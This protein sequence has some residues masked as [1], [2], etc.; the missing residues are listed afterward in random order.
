MAHALGFDGTEE[1][2]RTFG[3][4]TPLLDPDEIVFFAVGTDNLTSYER[5]QR[6]ARGLRAI[7]APAVAADPEA[8]AAEA[9][10]MLGTTDRILVHLDVDTIDYMDLPL[11]ENA[12]RNEGLAFDTTMRALATL[13]ATPKLAALTVTEVNPDHDPD[14]TA[15]ERFVEGLVEVLS[16]A[17]ALTGGA[18]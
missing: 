11:S 16:N 15:V 7:G 3:P 1:R 8:S 12:G 18:R 14:G 9:L 5:E 10:A 2:L 6:A 17:T 13:V 4:R